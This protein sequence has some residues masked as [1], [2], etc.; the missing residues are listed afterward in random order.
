[1]CPAKN[2]FHGPQGGSLSLR[3]GSWAAAS[4]ARPTWT[5]TGDSDSEGALARRPTGRRPARQAGSGA[6]AC[7]CQQPVSPLV[8]L[9]FTTPRSVQVEIHE[10]TRP[11]Q[12]VAARTGNEELILPS[13]TGDAGCAAPESP[14]SSRCVACCE[15]SRRS[16]GGVVTRSRVAG[17]Q[18]GNCEELVRARTPDCT[19][20]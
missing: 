4:E 2:E 7:R 12:A 6:A 19:A 14:S 18:V 13:L 5:E 10:S 11:G 1:M 20:A 16:L 9:E 17:P 3:L 8:E 15:T